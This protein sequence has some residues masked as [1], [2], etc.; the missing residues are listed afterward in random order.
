M[1]YDK[2]LKIIEDIIGDDHMSS[3][4][5]TPI[6]DDAFKLSDAEKIDIIEKKSR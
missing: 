5:E 1:K 2:E 6:R 3:S 4:E